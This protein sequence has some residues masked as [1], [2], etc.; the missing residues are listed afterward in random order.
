MRNMDL[1]N[2]L[3]GKEGEQ[4][5]EYYWSLVIEPGWIQAGIWDIEGDKAE[6]ISISPTVAWETEGELL[7]AADAALSA[8][9]QNLPEDMVEPTKTVFG[10]NSSWVSEG[11]IKEEHLE[12]IRKL[13]TDLSLKPVGF[14]VIPEA[15]SHLLK[16]EE[17]APLNAVVLGVGKDSLEIALFRLGNL[18]GTSQ[19]AR[20]V[21]IVDDAAEGLVRFAGSEAFPSR[22]I[23]YDGK[24]GELD[25][26]KQALFN[27][28]WDSYAKIKFLH[29]QR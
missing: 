8:S 4:G 12:R 24:E 1:K 11:Q 26:V 20:S 5:K 2:F 14:V 29:T 7:N 15:I 19:I 17:G 6:V 22:I 23:L 28:S 21:S 27:V 10:V 3:S 16:A 9:I 25:E 18:V 13:C